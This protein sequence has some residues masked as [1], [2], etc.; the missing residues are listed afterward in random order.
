MWRPLAGLLALTVAATAQ[1]QSDPLQ[2]LVAAR[3]FAAIR[4][5]GAGVLPG[6]IRLYETSADENFKARVA[7]AFYQ[8]GWKS[9]EAKRV[10]IRDAYTANAALRLQVQ[11]ALG[12]VSNDPDVVDVLLYN[13]TDDANPQFRDKAACALANDQIHLTDRQ[14]V[15]LFE[16]VIDALRDEKPDVR[17]IA[18]QVLEIHTGQ[19]KGFNP[20]APAAERGRAVRAWRQWLHDYK[21]R[22]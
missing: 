12:R 17:R 3:N 5:Q 15:K 13:M 7:E 21:S 16:G 1:A 18:A 10:L 2:G 11:W 22:L 8:L 9:A 4:A 6:L 14:K 20:E 19:N